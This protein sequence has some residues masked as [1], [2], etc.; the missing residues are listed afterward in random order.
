MYYIVGGDGKQYGP[1]TDVD[2]RKWIAEGR[3]NQQ[4]QAR[5]ESET[6]F[7]A[8]A[9]FPEF[10]AHFGIS[11]ATGLP[12]ALGT[13][14]SGREAAADRVKVPAIGLIV[15]G[16]INVILSVWGL[17]QVLFVKP[18][19]A[20]FNAQMDQLN[21]VNPQIG[22]FMQQWV[23]FLYG[24][25]GIANYIFQLIISVLILMG[26]L[27]MLKLRS[28]EFSYAAAILSFLPCISPCCCLGLVF[29]IW[30]IV[31]L[32]KADVKTQFS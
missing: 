22:Q 5:A 12:P 25:F 15:V 24:P 6:E 11:A 10:A 32:S 8:L 30:A 2:V 31:V 20:Q 17:I 7:R 3:L 9:G 23:H 28:F 14:A 27:K 4:S 1:I 26:A 29:G 21:S 16:V 19:V 13:D 18:D